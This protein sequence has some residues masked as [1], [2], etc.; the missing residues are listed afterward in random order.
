TGRQAYTLRFP[1]S[2]GCEVVFSPDGRLLVVGTAG[3]YLG[4]ETGAWQTVWRIP[5]EN[6]GGQTGIEAFSPDGRLLAV[7]HSPLAVKLCRTDTAAEAARLPQPDSGMIGGLG[8]SPDGTQLVASTEDNRV[9]V[10]DLRTIR[11]GLTRL[12][13]DWEL[14]PYPPVAPAETSPV[15][16]DLD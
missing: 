2:S 8:F 5:R 13:L 15:R 1:T 4:V 11:A 16:L 9:F 3:E 10:W 7:A 14:P 12:G 6:G